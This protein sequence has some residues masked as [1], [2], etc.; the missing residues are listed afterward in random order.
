MSKQATSIKL[1]I[2]PPDSLKAP[3]SLN[4]FT[5]DSQEEKQREVN[6]DDLERAAIESSVRAIQ[7]K[8]EENIMFGNY[9]LSPHRNSTIKIQKNSPS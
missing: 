3:G 9:N 4:K 5:D 8:S 7:R 2:R 6:V 1:D